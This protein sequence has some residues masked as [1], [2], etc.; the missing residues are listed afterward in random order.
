MSESAN[1]DSDSEFEPVNLRLS[2]RRVK[3]KRLVGQIVLLAFEDPG[4]PC[5]DGQLVSAV[6]RRADAHAAYRRTKREARRK[7]LE[8]APEIIAE[9]EE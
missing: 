1:A 8:V 3:L 2:R 7:G 6:L 9:P 4:G 5:Y